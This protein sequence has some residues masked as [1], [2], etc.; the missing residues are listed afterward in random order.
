LEIIKNARKILKKKILGVRIT[1]SDHLRG[2]I[3]LKESIRFSKDLEKL[4][5]DYICVSS[6]GIIAK[7]KMKLKNGHRLPLAKA[8]KNKIKIPVSSTGQIDNARIISNSIKKK[9]IDFAVVGRRFINDR[10][11]LSKELKKIPYPYL[12][13]IKNN[14]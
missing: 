3:D 7:T 11:W 9:Y 4:G 2:G 10:F 1:G 14:E 12:R 5:V 13:C 6:G 8:I